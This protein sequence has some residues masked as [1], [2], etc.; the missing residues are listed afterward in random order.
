MP[1]KTSPSNANFIQGMDNPNTPKYNYGC[2][3]RFVFKKL[4]TKEDPFM[5]HKIGGIFA[6]FSFLYRYLYVWPTVGSLNLKGHTFDWVTMVMHMLLSL[7]S[8]QFRVPAKKMPRRPTMIWEEYRLHAIIFTLKVHT[9][10][11]RTA[12]LQNLSQC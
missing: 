12:M 5:I 9:P 7:S 11:P 3:L 2:D 8:I 6:I 10:P 4:V 1:L